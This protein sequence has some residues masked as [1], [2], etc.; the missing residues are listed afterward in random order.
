MNL[1]HYIEKYKSIPIQIKA[2]IWFLVCAFVQKSISAITTPIFTRLMSTNEYGEYSVFYSWQ[3]IINC[4]VTLNLYGG[5][6]AQSIVKK[7]GQEKKQFISSMQGLTFS[8]VIGWLFVYIIGYKFWNNVFSLKTIQMVLMFVTIWTAAVFNFW[9]V[10]QRVDLKFKKLVVITLTIS[11]ANPVMGIIFINVCTDKVTARIMGSVVVEVIICIFLFFNQLKKGKTFF[12]KTNWKYALSLGVPLI[13]HYLSQMVLNSSDRIMIKKLVDESSTGIYNLAYSIS[14]IMLL[15]NTSLLQT[16]EPWIYQKIKSKEIDRI[17]TVAYPSF[18]M[19]AVINVIL[20]ALAPEVV[21]IFAPPA[22]Y[23]AIWVVPPV[24]M[25]VF[26]MYLYSFFALFEFYFEKPQYITIATMTGAVINIIMNYIFIKKYGYIAA[27]Y[28]TLACYIIYA[29]M[30]YI[31]MRR[32]I[33]EKLSGERV[34]DMH[35]IVCIAIVFLITSFAI[36]I[37]YNYPVV[38][39][40]VLGAMV[41][42]IVLKRKD[43]VNIIRSFI[44]LRKSK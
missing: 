20:I 29:L 27:G 11:I 25:S 33:D 15:F 39:Y 5:I 26:F 41:L 36:M 40:S 12:V 2:S 35:I 32:V 16:V 34:Y 28:T 22:Y 18:I 30:H 31:F 13:P 24:T 37:T 43:L 10:E 17:K 1:S 19:I 42:I 38:R 14:M 21:K 4:L 3:S 44:S 8:L 6:Y 23:E 9:S 7:E